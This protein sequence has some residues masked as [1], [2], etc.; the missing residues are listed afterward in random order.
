MRV[1]EIGLPQISL[2]MHRCLLILAATNELVL[3][4]SCY[5]TLS[6]LQAP[7]SPRTRKVCFL[8]LVR[9]KE[10]EEI[11]LL[12]KEQTRPDGFYV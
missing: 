7:Q 12:F 4:H 9:D 8:I 1:R 5:S 6:L 2:H 11:F 3:C 10:S